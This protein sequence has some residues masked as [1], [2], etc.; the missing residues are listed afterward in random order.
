[1]LKYNARLEEET[2]ETVPKDLWDRARVL[3][4]RALA[5]VAVPS[6]PHVMP[7]ADGVI[8]FVWGSAKTSVHVELNAD[9]CA[10]NI[11]RPNFPTGSSTDDS[12]ILAVLKSVFGEK[13]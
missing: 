1:M 3:L 9:G 12:D 8:I 13:R 11:D 2:G 4:T 5:E 6:A 7:H 10:W